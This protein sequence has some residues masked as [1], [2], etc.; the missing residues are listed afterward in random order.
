MDLQ[1]QL[2]GKSDMVRNV[3][4]DMQALVNTLKEQIQALEGRLNSTEEELSMSINE[5]SILK[6]EAEKL[7]EKLSNVTK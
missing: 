5:R 7:S 2:D 1:D 3:Q 6:K 4:T